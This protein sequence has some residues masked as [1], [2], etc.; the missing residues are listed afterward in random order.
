MHVALLGDSILDNQTYTQ[1]EPDVITHLRRMLPNS[2]QATLCAIDGSTTEDLGPQIARVPADAS[3][4]VVSIGGNDALDNIDLLATPV[5]STTQALSLFHER[6]ERF[7]IAYRTALES[8]LSLHR[9]TAVCTIYNGNLEP[10]EAQLARIL[11][12]MFNDVILRFGFERGL[13]LIDLRIILTEKSDY[14]NPI[15]PSGQGGF[16]IARSIAGWLGV[17]ESRQ[18]ARVYTG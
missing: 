6:I 10:P 15:E 4:L 5:K 7:E 11:L 1:G 13:D 18:V 2:A 3:H 16:K 17:R 12:M 14:A 9:K 8:T